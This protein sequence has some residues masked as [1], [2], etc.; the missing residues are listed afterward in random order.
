[1]LKRL[2]VFLIMTGGMLIQ[3]AWAVSAANAYVTVSSSTK[4]VEDIVP[5][6]TDFYLTTRGVGKPSFK[7]DIDIKAND[8]YYL[9][10]PVSKKMRLGIEEKEEYKVKDE[11]GNEDAFKGMVHVL[12]LDI[13]PQET[14]VCWKSTS[15]TLKLTEDSFPGGTAIWTSVPEGIDGRGK[16]ITFNPNVLTAGVYTVTARSEIVSSYKDSCIVR[17]VAS[18]LVLYVDQPG[19]GGDRD[20]YEIG[21]TGDKKGSVDVDVGHTFWV[22]NCSYPNAILDEQLRVYVNQPM[23]YYP[24]VGVSPNSPTSPGKLVIPDTAHMAGYEVEHKWEISFSQLL[25]G[26]QYS[27][28]LHDSPGTYNLNSNNCTDA[29]VGAAAAVGVTISTQQGTW[30]GGGGRNPGDLGEDLRELAD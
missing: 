5:I 1:M 9:V 15:C 22:Y 23:G 25:N 30:P 10:K 24:I 29:A 26:L 19:S 4:G 17:V 14:N 16:S 13:E 21:V 8:P 7:A 2:I 12:K 6:K 27:K 11:S 3:T 20:T 18:T 28:N